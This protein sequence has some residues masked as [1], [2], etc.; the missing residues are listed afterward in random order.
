METIKKVTIK[1]NIAVFADYDY[2]PD[3]IPYPV[4]PDEVT[5]DVTVPDYFDRSDA[6][7]RGK[8][9]TLLETYD[10]NDYFYSLAH[11]SLELYQKI[12]RILITDINEYINF[13]AI[14]IFLKKAMNYFDTTETNTLKERLAIITQ[15]WP[16]NYIPQS[17]VVD[18]WGR[19][20][21]GLLYNSKYPLDFY[22]TMVVKNYE[23]L[24]KD[25]TPKGITLFRKRG[26]LFNERTG[27]FGE[28]A[29]DGRLFEVQML[30][31]DFA[32]QLPII[33]TKI[34]TEKDPRTGLWIPVNVKTEKRGPYPF[35][36]RH[37]GTNQ[38]GESMEVWM[39][40]QQGSVKMYTPDYD[41]CSRF[42]KSE[43]CSG[44]GMNDLECKWVN[45]KC[46]S[47][48]GKQKN[49]PDIKYLKNVLKKMF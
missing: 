8:L 12:K 39:E 37:I 31:K 16:K 42:T 46:V 47:S 18:F 27:K 35:I 9:I 1:S 5:F 40:V 45:R 32:T 23:K 14:N 15:K 6:T 44:P 26:I 29:F 2:L 25:L 11:I 19:D 41:T 20:L 30:D 36:L 28:Q 34:I 48:F 33:Q 21:F 3:H 49:L 38:V 10:L 4:E 17:T 24:V 13:E 43:D 22:Q 7:K